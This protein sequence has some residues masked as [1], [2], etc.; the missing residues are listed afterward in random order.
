VT[1][2]GR[3]KQCG[4]LDGLFADVR[5]GRSRALVV[6]GEPGIGKTA[7][8]GYAAQTAQDFQVARA[9]GVESEME[10]PFAALHQLCGR[11]LSRL[12]LLPGPQRDAL[13]VAFGLCSGSAPDRLLVGLAV[14]GLLS[15]VAADQPLLCL[16][17]DAQWLDQA[18]AQAL[19][20]VARRL[21]AESVAMLF[22]TRDPATGGDLAGLPELA[23]QGLSDV[24]ARA[25]LASV[26]PGPLDERVRD[27]II[28]ESGGNPLALLELP[29]G[30]TA[31]ELAGGFGLPG[32]G[33]L[34]GR[35]EDIF[36]RRLAPLPATTRQL[37]LLAAA[38]PT[39]DPALLWRAADRLGIGI[40]AADAA[41][42][43][44]LLEFGARLT[45]RH[46]LVRSAIYR[47]TSPGERRAVHRALAEAT[48][49]QLDPDR[50]A[51]HR[52]H[53]AV[54]PDED[55]AAELERSAGRAQ[56]G[57]GLAAAAALLEQAARL[58]PSPARRGERA[59]AAAKA[60]HQAGAPDAALRLLATA[61]AGPLDELQRA[62][63]DL[64]RGQIAFAV[65]RGRDAPPLLLMAAKRLEP[66]DVGLARETYLDALWA[67]MFVGRLASGSGLLEVA[68]A[69]RGAPPS[70]QPPRAADLLLDGLALLI[71]EGYPAG[72]PILRRALSAFRSED[73]SREEG[74]RWLWLACRAAANLWDDETWAVLAIRQVQL[75][76]DAGALTVLPVALNSRI[77]MHLNAGELAAAAALI[78][79]AQAITDGTGSRLAPYGVVLLASWRGREAEASELIDASLKEV[80]ARGEGLGLTVIQWAS[81]VLYNGL[82]RYQ[83]AV[84]AAQRAGE[85]PHEQLFSIWAAVELIEAATRSGVPEHAASALERLSRST[86]ASGT[87]WALGIQARSRALVSDGEPAERL[88]REAIDRLG[89]TRMRVELARAHLLYGEWLRRENRRI[90]AREQLR[91]AHQMLTSMGADGFAE[92]A[93]RELRATGERVRKRTI[94]TPAQLT[95]RETQ[96]ARLAGDG[97]S[98]PEIA[99]QLFMSPRTVEYHLHKIFTKLA[100]NSRNQLHSALANDRSD[101]RW[102][103]A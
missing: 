47:S 92:R 56:A 45:F 3:R 62:R 8:L 91:T 23:L 67:A 51:L 55:V 95:A 37:L 80:L 15:G 27:R 93:A 64:L 97:L 38:E 103:T 74:L 81:A 86:G 34:S 9:E 2:W 10:L 30:A 20:F 40:E 61:Q 102:Q 84:A 24:D 94:D 5:A 73:V 33:P 17:D 65:N 83:D 18:S 4:A 63:V 79:E 99:A 22:G 41:E 32:A 57:G 13:G 85:D 60:K 26:L 82:G 21:D 87:D 14:L 52:A 25:L 101:G 46:P 16:I 71:T 90:D 66:L 19:A 44:G 12:D 36:R 48:D 98:N 31:A 29:H 76:R 89:R 7:L 59:L 96:I 42:S 69:A 77:Y 70:S 28:A 35:I 49:P 58:T 1:L 50:R 75:A 100:I 39:G 43:E 78:E 53:A 11:M 72:T 6:R 54:G 68:Q 88:Y